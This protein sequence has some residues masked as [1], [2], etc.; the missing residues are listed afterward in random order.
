[1]SHRLDT[2]DTHVSRRTQR[3]PQ[4]RV[5]PIAGIWALGVHVIGTPPTTGP[6]EIY[7]ITG[8]VASP[9]DGAA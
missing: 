2:V 1:M 5:N 3:E 7:Q 9:P 6:D 8:V 4:C